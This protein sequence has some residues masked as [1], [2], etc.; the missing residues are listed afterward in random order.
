MNKAKTLLWL[1]TIFCCFQVLG[2]EQSAGNDSIVD[3]PKITRSEII[4]T[5]HKFTRIHWRMEK[6]I[7]SDFG[8]EKIFWFYLIISNALFIY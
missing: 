4:L 8:K 3:G 1:V 7:T 2:I 5:A 6:V